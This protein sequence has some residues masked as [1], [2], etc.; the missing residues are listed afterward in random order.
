MYSANLFTENSKN[1]NDFLNKFYEK[2]IKLNENLK[3]EAEFENPVDMI[4]LI[5]TLIDNNEKF[6]IGIWISI[7][8][9]LYINITEQNLDKVIKYIFER[10]PY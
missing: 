6:N 4:E 5:S 10:Y 9:D 1:L 2:E 7:D 3:F 8:P